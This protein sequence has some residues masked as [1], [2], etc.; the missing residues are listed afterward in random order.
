[1]RLGGAV[2]LYTDFVLDEK[3]FEISVR[4]PVCK[5]D[6]FVVMEA[7]IDC[8]M[9]MSTCPQ[10]ILG[11]NVGNIITETHFQLIL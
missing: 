2:N 4:D 9:V 5:A 6:D 10:D 8:Y 1:M 3:D 7:L 11:G